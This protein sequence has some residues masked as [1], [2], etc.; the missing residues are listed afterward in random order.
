MFIHTNLEEMEIYPR[1]IVRW[2][3][4]MCVVSTRCMV[5]PNEVEETRVWT[6]YSSISSKQYSSKCWVHEKQNMFNNW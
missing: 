3:S 2:V 6:H 1:S 4:W 5:S